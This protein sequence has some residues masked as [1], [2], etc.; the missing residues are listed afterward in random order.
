MGAIDGSN[1]ALQ[2]LHTKSPCFGHKLRAP[3]PTRYTNKI[4]SSKFFRGINLSYWVVAS[5]T[6]FEAYLLLYRLKVSYPPPRTKPFKFF[7]RDLNVI[8]KYLHDT[9]KITIPF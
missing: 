9:S 2:R 6:L 8:P 3:W 4:K 7:S 1:L 5:R